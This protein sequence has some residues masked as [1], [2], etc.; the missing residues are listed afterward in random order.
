MHFGRFVSR[1]RLAS[2]SL[3][4]RRNRGAQGFQSSLEPREPRE[5]RES[6]D[7]RCTTDAETYYESILRSISGRSFMMLYGSL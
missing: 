6:T 7:D 5:P 4:E 2:F 1:C 3:L